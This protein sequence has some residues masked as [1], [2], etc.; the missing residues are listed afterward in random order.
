MKTTCRAQHLGHY[1]KGQGHNMT[2][3]Q[4]RVRPITSIRGALPGSDR[5]M[6]YYLNLFHV[7]FVDTEDPWQALTD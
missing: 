1:L 7:F 6:F 5:L 4:N 3:Q 2:M